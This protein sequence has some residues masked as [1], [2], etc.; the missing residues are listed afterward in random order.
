MVYWFVN[1]FVLL[2]CERFHS[3]KFINMHLQD[4]FGNHLTITYS[5]DK[6]AIWQTSFGK[7]KLEY[8][9]SFFPIHLLQILKSTLPLRILYN[10]NTNCLKDPKRRND[11]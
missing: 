8:D 4:S 3:L 11:T 6:L 5:F 7:E 9:V 10:I 2:K 1:T